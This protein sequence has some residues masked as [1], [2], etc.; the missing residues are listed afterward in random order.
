MD[1]V[2]QLKEELSNL[3]AKREKILEL[4]DTYGSPQPMKE[5][6]SKSER[7][8]H[9]IRDMVKE[10]KSFH[11]NDIEAEIERQGIDYNK[12]AVHQALQSL[13]DAGE[14]V[15]V[16]INKSNQKYYYLSPEG[17]NGSKYKVKDSYLPMP[18]LFIETVDVK[19]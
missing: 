7:Y 8:R 16:K 5:D 12:A 11:I 9:I 6:I 13:R 19:E 17:I 18:K 10:E 15:A 2:K 3:D 14:V 1:I 4:I